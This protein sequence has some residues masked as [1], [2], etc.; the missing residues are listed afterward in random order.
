[1]RP[2]RLMPRHTGL[3]GLSIAPAEF[4]LPKFRKAAMTAVNRRVQIAW[5]C[6]R[7]NACHKFTIARRGLVAVSWPQSA[8]RSANHFFWRA[9][10]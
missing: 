7:W 10:G 3:S 5:E 6:V 2:D 1:M 9:A 8:D 4:Q